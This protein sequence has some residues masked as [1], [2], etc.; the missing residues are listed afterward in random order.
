MP[1][2]YVYIIYGCVFVCL[3]GWVCS[4]YVGNDFQEAVAYGYKNVRGIRR[5]ASHHV[6]LDLVSKDTLPLPDP[7]MA[8]S[9]SQKHYGLSG[10]NWTSVC[11]TISFTISAIQRH[12]AVMAVFSMSIRI[13]HSSPFVA[14]RRHSGFPI[15]CKSH[16]IILSPYQ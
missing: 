15:E 14:I 3:C 8:F 2:R 10:L 16:R 1:L 9:F 7:W 11:H 6:T 12:I 4:V 5:L 13:H